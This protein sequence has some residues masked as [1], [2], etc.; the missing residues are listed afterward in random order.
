M[1]PCFLANTWY[2]N[3]TVLT[4]SEMGA[5]EVQW[6]RKWVST[7]P[8]ESGCGVWPG[9]SS[10]RC[11][12]VDSGWFPP[13]TVILRA[14]SLD[15]HSWLVVPHNYKVHYHCLFILLIKS[16]SNRWT[17]MEINRLIRR[18]RRKEHVCNQ[19]SACFGS[20]DFV[21]ICW[22]TI[23][24]SSGI[25][26][27]SASDCWGAHDWSDLW[28]PVYEPPSPL[29][30][31][32]QDKQLYIWSVR[33]AYYDRRSAF[34]VGPLGVGWHSSERTL[35]HVGRHI[36]HLALCIKSM[37]GWNGSGT[38][39]PVHLWLWS[40]DG[41]HTVRDPVRD[42]WLLLTRLPP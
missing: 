5:R 37:G 18:R 22:Q 42:F 15:S 4:S 25:T 38:C 21:Q 3:L 10:Y 40:V 28:R 1:E 29:S 36:Y 17:N 27:A 24:N 6:E 16:F 30:T 32:T 31:S 39:C 8:L 7:D 11:L 19:Q 12:N 9:M 41:M 23:N 13:T 34:I 20:G 14:T 26:S 35:H 2:F 33:A